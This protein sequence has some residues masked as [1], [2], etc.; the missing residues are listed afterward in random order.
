MRWYIARRALYTLGVM[1]VASVVIFYALRVAPG[2]PTDAILNPLALARART[3]MRHQLGLDLPIYQ[4]YFVY[5]GHVFQGSLGV[6][7]IN[8][9]KIA[10]II[11]IFGVRT[12]ELGLVATI[13]TYLI[14]IPAGV[15]AALHHNRL[16]DR[17]IMLTANLGMGI[18]NF[19]LALLF[20]LLFSVQLG[21]LPPSGS[22]SPSHLVLPAVVLATEGIAVTTRLMRSSLLDQL[23]Q[24]Y[25]RTLRAKGLSQRRIVWVHAVRNALI[26]VI[27]LAGLRLGW[28]IG[29]TLIVEIVFQWPGLGYELVNSVIA[30]DYPVAQALSLLLTFAVLVS[31]FL[32]NVAYAA[33]DPRIRRA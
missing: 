2:D 28:L 29:Y 24:D 12:L 25:I 23:G 1:V 30:R 6:S 13:L 20:I 7:L 5:M 10:S 31:N 26:P 3:A 21:W 16:L 8:G 22:G 14:A 15:W 18:P 4:Q 11:G 19:W 27:S 33:V 9:Q 32:A 17:A